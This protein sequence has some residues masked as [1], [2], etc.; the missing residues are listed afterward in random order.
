MIDPVTRYILQCPIGL[1]GKEGEAEA[2][3]TP[4]APSAFATLHP[5]PVL[6]GKDGEKRKA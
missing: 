6:L 2:V 5:I 1:Q 3:G 4:C